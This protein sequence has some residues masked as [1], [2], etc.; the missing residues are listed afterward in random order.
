MTTSHLITNGDLSLLCDINADCLIY[1]GC[2]LI[3]VLLG[4]YLWHPLQ[5]HIRHEVPLR[6]YLFTSLAFTEDGTQT[7]LLRS[8]QS[9]P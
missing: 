5:Y 1:S 9:L 7:S 8:V 4:K 3:A 6:R 2:Q